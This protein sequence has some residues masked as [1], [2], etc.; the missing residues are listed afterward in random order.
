MKLVFF[1]SGDYL[2]FE[3]ENN[4]FIQKWFQYIFDQGINSFHIQSSS[5][6][7]ISDDI[8]NLNNSIVESVKYAESKVKNF[9]NNF[10][11]IDDLDQNDLNHNHKFW[12]STTQKYLDK[13]FP[14]PQIWH[15][16]NEYIHNI[17]NHYYAFFQNNF[18]NSHLDKR[19]TRFLNPEDFDYIQSDLMIPYF[20]L[21]RHQY[22]QWCVDSDIDEE[23]D[24]YDTVAL[25]FTYY[26]KI[27]NLNNNCRSLP[28][29]GYE[30]WCKKQGLKVL[31]P[32]LPLGK[33]LRY[34]KF[35]IRKLM[36]RNLY[37]NKNS[38]NI[39]FEY[40]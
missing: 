21:G 9:R 19:Y 17:E 38:T 30:E 1:D 4:I 2:D 36:H 27:E 5:C 11:F 24:N 40:G 29:S 26:C 35:E 15:D 34:N 3:P 31:P 25:S 18:I 13:L 8:N 14:Q 32:Y 12:V 39:G 6:D 7:R 22:N 28:P 20:N 23:T 37:K 33:F 10:K 16:V